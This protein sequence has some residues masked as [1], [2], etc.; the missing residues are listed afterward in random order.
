MLLNG[1][2]KSVG[3]K[4]EKKKHLTKTTKNKKFQI[5]A[6]TLTHAFTKLKGA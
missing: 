6:A 4:K 3:I 1:K 2:Q 5:Y